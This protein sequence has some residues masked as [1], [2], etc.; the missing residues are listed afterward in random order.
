MSAK[1]LAKKQKAA[2]YFKQKLLER[3]NKKDIA[4][5]VLFGSVARQDPD[6]DDY[7]DIDVLLFTTKP[8]KVREAAWE[9]S[10]DTYA[11][12]QESVEPLVYSTKELKSPD[13]YFL[14]YSIQKGKQLYPK[15]K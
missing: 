12:Y 7:S 6:V 14:Y 3:G 15:V 11:K 5:I 8:K 4:K 2:E 1:V 13:S 9:A 10:L